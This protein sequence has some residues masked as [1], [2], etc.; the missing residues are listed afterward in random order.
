MSMLMT[1]SASL[2]A[3]ASRIQR[4]VL[5]GRDESERP[6]P[7]VRIELGRWIPAGLLNVAV[8]ALSLI[9]A[10]QVATAAGHWAMAIVGAVAMAARPLPGMAQLYALVL[11]GGLALTASDPWAPKVFI[12]IFGVHLFVQL[13]SLTQGLRWTTRVELAALAAPGRRFLVVQIGAQAAAV[14]GAWLAGRSI[15]AGWA[16]VLA[17]GCLA[18]LALVLIRSVSRARRETIN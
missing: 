16:A 17:G 15:D 1:M 2:A 4:T 13:G 18:A 9:C 7:Q 5:V 12:L 3:A 6:L 8:A 10:A 14:G 11:G